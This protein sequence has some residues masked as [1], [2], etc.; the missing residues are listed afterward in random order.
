[1]FRRLPISLLIALTQT[2]PSWAVDLQPNDVVAPLPDK[3]FLMVTYYDTENTTFYKNGS[4][5]TKAP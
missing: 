5:V 4:V 1:M 2:A 3:N